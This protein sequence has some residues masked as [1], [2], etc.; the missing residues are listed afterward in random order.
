MKILLLASLTKNRSGNTLGG[1]EKSII[2]LATWLSENTDNEVVL[3]SVE[4]NER[5][6]KIGNKVKYIGYEIDYRNKVYTHIQ[7]LRNTKEI[8]KNENPDFLISFWIHPMFYGYITRGI[9][10]RAIY[11]E[12]NDPSLEYGIFTKILRWVV[13]QKVCGIVFQTK[14]AMN[15]FAKNIKKKSVVIHNPV[16]IKK[17]DFQ[18]IVEY[19]KR[20]VN[21]GRLNE[22]KNQELLID[23]FA[24]I[25]DLYPEYVLEIYGD[26]PLKKKLQK[27]IEDNGLSD[28]VKLMGA[29]K[30]VINRI[31]G[32]RLFVLSSSYEGMP[33]ALLEAMSIGV[34]VISSD[35]PCG[36]PKEIIEDGINGYL[37]E[38]E[39]V[40]SLI[41]VINRAF[42][43]DPKKISENEKKIC[44]THSADMIFGQWM[45]YINKLN[46]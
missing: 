15:Y 10:C 25:S 7:I 42:K 4:G 33:N 23:A 18:S 19:D 35:C 45:D 20:I 22:Q 38:V 14:E 27:K 24:K 39:N 37:F 5:P 12:R 6:F 17:N 46:N 3:A 11:S 21:V 40:D 44:N 41:T 28:R 9:K 43:D 36:G 2:Y 29:H 16:Y 32:A 26:G 13:L 8:L 30:D 1:A 31:Y 34:P